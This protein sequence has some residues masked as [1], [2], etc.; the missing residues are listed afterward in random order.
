MAFRAGETIA[1]GVLVL[2]AAG[3]ASALGAGDG[4]SSAIVRAPRG[5]TL[6]PTIAM[7]QPIVEA[8]G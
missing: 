1:D 6:T 7:W 3:A 4:F 8:M 5:G 2:D